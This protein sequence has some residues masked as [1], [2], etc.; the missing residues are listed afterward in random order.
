M[1]RDGVP[2]VGVYPL[3]GAS[4]AAVEIK[5]VTGGGRSFDWVSNHPLDRVIVKGGDAAHVYD[6][7]TDDDP[8]R[9][10]GLT[11][12]L[13]STGRLPM[14]SHVEYCYRA[15]LPPVLSADT[16]QVDGARGVAIDDVPLADLPASLV[17]LV[18][19]T[20]LVND[21]GTG[22]RFSGTS[23]RFSGTGLRF[24]GTGLRFSGTGLRFSG[25]GL[26]FSGTSLRFSGTGLRFSGTGLRF[27]G[28]S[29]RFSDSGVGTFANLRSIGTGLRFSGTGLRFSDVVPFAASDVPAW[30][31]PLSD[32][33]P[34]AGYSW[35]DLFVAIGRYQ[36]YPTQNVTFGQLLD[37]LDE[38]FA[39]L[40][41]TQQS[42]PSVPAVVTAFAEMSLLD[43][44][45]NGE[46]LRDVSLIGILLGA[47]PLSAIPLPGGVTWCSLIDPENG[48][49][50]DA[51]AGAMT[52]LGLN[53]AGFRSDNV[54]LDEILLSAVTPHPDSV[55]ADLLADAPGVDDAYVP[56]E[57]GDT[58][59]S[60]VLRG[61]DALNIPWEQLPLRTDFDVR[62]YALG[63]RV[64]FTGRWQ[65]PANDKTPVSVQ[66]PTGFVLAEGSPSC[67][68]SA[69]SC[70][71]TSL[72]SGQ[73]EVTVANAT[74]QVDVTLT[75]AY[76]PAGLYGTT[77]Q[78]PAS[79][80]FSVTVSGV[81]GTFPVTVVDPWAG[82]NPPPIDPDVLYFGNAGAGEIDRYD[83]DVSEYAPGSHVAVR[84]SNLTD[85]A[86][87][88]LYR[89]AGTSL[90]FSGTSMRFSG[91]GL[92]FSGTGLRFSGD[93]GETA[94][95]NL[96]PETLED[97][98]VDADRLV[99]DISANRRTT[100]EAADGFTSSGTDG[101]EVQVSG[102]NQA[103]T[104]Y[105]VRV[106]VTEFADECTTTAE[107]GAS[108]SFSGPANATTAVLFARNR[109]NGTDAA[110]IDAAL[111]RLSAAGWPLAIGTVAT[112][113]PDWATES[114]FC[115]VTAANAVA[116]D[117]AL[118]VRNLDA[119]IEHVMVIGA[120]DKL[121]FYR[122]A[123]TALIANEANY[124]STV[125]GTNAVT[126]ALAT[127][128]VLT[129]DIYGD[130][131][132]WPFLNRL[133]FTPDR[134]V[135]RLVETRADIVGQIDAFIGSGGTVDV[136]RA[137]T[138][139][140]DFLSDVAVEIDADLA[141]VTPNRTT[142]ISDVPGGAP[143][144]SIADLTAALAGDDGGASLSLASYQAHMD[145]G[146]LLSALGDAQGDNVDPAEV[147][148]PD[149][150]IPAGVAGA[151]LFTA[152]CHGGLNQP[153]TEGRS[154]DWA[155]SLAGGAAAFYLANT[156]YGYGLDQPGIAYSEELLESFA[157]LLADDGLTVGQAAALAKQQF[158]ASQVEIDPYDE[159]SQMQLTV[160][161][162]PMYA[163]QAPAPIAAAT[164]LSENPQA[165]Q[166]LSTT[167][168]PDPVTGQASSTLSASLTFGTQ[169]G[170][171]G[172]SFP[173][174]STITGP[175][176]AEVGSEVSN[177]DPIQPKFTSDVTSSDP[178]LIARGA[179]VEQLHST[180]VASGNPTI[181]RPIVDN[182]AIEPPA[183][184]GVMIFP[185]AFTNVHTI[186]TPD[187]PRSQLVV[188][189][190][191]YDS[192]DPGREQ[193][194]I[195]E[196]TV[197]NYYAGA[198][199]ADVVRPQFNDVSAGPVGNDILFRIAIT[200][201]EGA[202]VTTTGIDRVL[203]QY[204]DG[205]I[206]H[207][208]EAFPANAERTEWSAGLRNGMLSTD[209]AAG[210]GV[211]FVQAVDGAGNVSVSANKG[212]NY[213]IEGAPA[214]AVAFVEGEEG[215]NGWYI[216]T[217]VTVELKGSAVGAGTHTVSIDGGAPTPYTGAFDI[218]KQGITTV[219]I[220]GEGAPP[221]RLEIK[222]D[223]LHPLV[224]LTDP[225]VL[226]TFNELAPSASVLRCE[227]Q[228][229]PDAPTAG[230]GL[231]GSCEVTT[232]SYPLTVGST[233]KNFELGTARGRDVA[234]NES[235]ESQTAVVLDGTL[236]SNGY[237]T[238]PVVLGVLGADAASATVKL[239]NGSPQ[240]YAGPI[241]ITETTSVTVAVGEDV[242][243]FTVLV[244]RTAPTIGFS[245]PPSPFPMG[246]AVTLTCAFN[247]PG[248][249]AS[250]LAAVA[251]GSASSP[252]AGGAVANS[253]TVPLDTSAPGQFT[254]SASA[255]DAAGNTS[256]ASFT[257]TVINPLCDPRGDVQ[258]PNAD[259]VECVQTDNRNRTA[260]LS[261]IVD[262]DIATAGVQYRLRLASSP[263][264]P[265][266]L[267]K[268]V[269]GKSS[270]SQ[271]ISASINPTRSDRIDFVVD[272]R[273]LGISS[274]M[275]L[276]W[277]AEV[278]DGVSGA[279]AA[280]FLDRAPDTP[281]AGSPPSAG[282]FQLGIG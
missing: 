98:P 35:N 137:F 82:Q 105:V 18:A 21:A 176:D 208:V 143:D 155:E 281:P 118:A 101:F 87:L 5:R 165:I 39:G 159:K 198:T 41:G 129:D 276:Y 22:L 150:V 232:A 125:G 217:P 24:S 74:G 89:S 134:A 243:T 142:L 174:I 104:D 97:V 133:Y 109:F 6:E 111:A 153:Y 54:P 191:Q 167:P 238:T 214:L 157:E 249:G 9:G 274:G 13:N 70:V 145:Q 209:T 265:G 91:T 81:T 250:G 271:L 224:D 69:G 229:P 201:P 252:V 19:G 177:G 187:G 225:I 193:L 235:S 197:R 113:G 77:N 120:D 266:S 151:V 202:G 199:D 84:L 51:A 259:I 282:W 148:G 36:G 226:L 213:K 277:F 29:L 46:L 194:L 20:N 14:I 140:Y 75:L 34:P 272:L 103:S 139:G 219:E 94:V 244:D 170:P 10:T 16:N 116:E 211:Y 11:A 267:V 162:V 273:K 240:T 38:Y 242:R 241:S 190:A 136:D 106:A 4:G 123:D 206:W 110:A 221:I 86:D 196:I 115:S 210:G 132:P 90:R 234:G 256:T 95:E 49:C 102:F 57:A 30:N 135:G 53:L 72:G 203:V 254:V 76:R 164:A 114:G 15:K 60:Y 180:Q 168:I 112:T 88:V 131:D 212:E 71:V 264:A 184:S 207:P 192:T 26:R 32:L 63:E 2:V 275:T 78:P 263:T 37:A 73:F 117:V 247:D 181:A 64:T 93:N 280:G 55:L 67:V 231:V 237:Y 138:A 127:Q 248:A 178:T 124:A 152:G 218:T 121:P 50:T 158:F 3:P 216:D 171:R 166:T 92:R 255:T 236:G 183:P 223:T 233:T 161:G 48:G 68:A 128:H 107:A 130:V 163:L 239:G 1:K 99:E 108:V 79:G 270:G 52:L 149:I 44:D 195:D 160:Y 31:V 47:T 179:I 186:H 260:T 119:P 278:Q 189:P 7:S 28:T 188:V 261:I 8:R 147:K 23:L 58:L 200:D 96:E 222:I 43:L 80:N 258:N 279:P 33:L 126:S 169:P 25:T 220:V 154:D 62:E 42:P 146:L 268:W 185:T 17:N 83:A 122:T 100:P 175:A 12:P 85:D 40:G 205:T 66:A 251:C 156:G 245:A 144:W 45:P 27:S 141:G 262:G 59:A 230:S 65:Q 56:A 204:Y 61:I 227:E 182:T 215:D 246:S 172:T 269:E 173:V 257:Y 228:Y 253:L